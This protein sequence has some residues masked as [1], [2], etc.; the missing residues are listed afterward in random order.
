MSASHVLRHCSL[1]GLRCL[2]DVFPQEG[3][4]ER[5]SLTSKIL[6]AK[7]DVEEKTKELAEV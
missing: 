1:E 2:I 5:E 7:Y 3:T 4:E 6:L